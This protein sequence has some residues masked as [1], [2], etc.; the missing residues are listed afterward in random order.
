MEPL[1]IELEKGVVKSFDG[2]KVQVERL[3]KWMYSSEPHADLAD[4][5][6]IVTTTCIENDMYG[7]LIDGTHQTHCTHLALGNN[8]RRDE[9]IHA[10]EHCDFDLHNPHITLDGQTIYADRQF[11]DALIFSI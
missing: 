1:R 9:V 8:T 2:P 7:W 11:N 3:E 6:G 4:E 10:P 5:I